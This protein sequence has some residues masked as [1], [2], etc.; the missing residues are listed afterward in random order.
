MI[1]RRLAVD[2]QLAE[3]EDRQQAA[4]EALFTAANDGDAEGQQGRQ[5][6]D[7]AHSSQQRSGMQSG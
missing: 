1:Q 2:E 7:S 3:P 4:V 5:W 6:T